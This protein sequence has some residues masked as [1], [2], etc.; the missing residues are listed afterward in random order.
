MGILKF[1]RILTLVYSVIISA[2]IYLISYLIYRRISFNL[3]ETFF[4]IG[5]VLVLIG[6]V[7]LIAR[8]PMRISGFGSRQKSLQQGGEESDEEEVTEADEETLPDKKSLLLG[9]NS[10]TIALSGVILLVVDA[11]L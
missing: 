9:F 4:L 2:V 8:N 10:F 3:K 1:K 11:F 6:I 5:L 7:M